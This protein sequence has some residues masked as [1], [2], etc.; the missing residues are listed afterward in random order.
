MESGWRIYED[1]E[2]EE[3][4]GM[5]TPQMKARKMINEK[6]GKKFKRHQA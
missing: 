4:P 5:N 2:G 3:G 1:S 6:I